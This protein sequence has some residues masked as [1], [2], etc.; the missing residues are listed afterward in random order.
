MHFLRPVFGNVVIPALLLVAAQNPVSAGEQAFEARWAVDYGKDKCRLIRNLTVA[1]KAYRL[2]IERGLLW[3]GYSWNLYGTELP[4]YS[5]APPIDIGVE[6]RT[7]TQRVGAYSRVSDSDGEKA[8]SWFDADG[9]ILS[10]G[11]DNRYIRLTGPKKLDI[12]IDLP[13]LAEAIKAMDVCENDLLA[14]W[15]IDAARLRALAVRAEP[16][17]DPARWVMVN[18]YPLA[19]AASKNGGMV[20]FLISISAEGAPTGCRIVNSSGFASLDTRACQLVL[21]RAAFRPARDANGQSVPSFYAN[22]IFWKP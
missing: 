11:L 16:S 6:T 17:N 21:S 10:A 2:E 3:N 8:I 12:S 9:H 4:T 20:T 19:D 18:D 13:H 5:Q 7:G 14:S 1:G 15:G 22:R